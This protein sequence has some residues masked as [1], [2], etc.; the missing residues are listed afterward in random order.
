MLNLRIRTVTDDGVR[1]ASSVVIDAISITYSAQL[2]GAATLNFEASRD[3]WEPTVFPF[4]AQVEYSTDGGINY[5]PLPEHDLFIFERDS[6]D[7]KDQGKIVTYDGV[8]YVPWLLAGAYVGTGPWQENNERRINGDGSFNAQAGHIMSYFIDES[9]GR[10]WLSRLN[11]GFNA[12]LDSAGVAWQPSDYASIAWRLETFYTDVLD[13]L[14]E[15]GLCDWSATG[16]T[17]NLY[18]PDTLGTEKHDIV[19]GGQE[20]ERVPVATDHTGWYTHV[21]AISD[22]GRVHVHNTALETRFGRRSAVMSQTGVNDTTTSTKLA[23]TMLADGMI[24][25]RQEGYEWSPSSEGVHPWRDF[26]IGDHVTARARGGKRVRRVMGLIVTQNTE[27]ASVQAMVGEMIRSRAERNQKKLGSLSVGNIVGGSGGGYPTSPGVPEPVPSAPE[28]VI[29]ANNVGQWTDGGDPVS[30]VT[31]SWSPVTSSVDGEEITIIEYEVWSRTPSGN[32]A[33]DTIVTGTEATIDMWPSGEPR[34]VAV[35]ARSARGII[36]DFSL[37]LY[38]TPVYPESIVPKAPTNLDIVSNTATF[39]AVGPVAN[40]ILV[41]DAVTE[42]TDD[43]PLTVPEYEVWADGAP[44]TRIANT[45]VAITQPS[46]TVREYRVGAITAQGVR[47]D[48][49]TP[50]SV[51]GATPD[52]STATP[53]APLL[54]S[55]GANIIAAWD[56]GFTAP[57]AGTHTV[58]VEARIGSGAWIRQGASLST[59]GSQLVRLGDVGDTVEVR[60]VAI[61]PLGRDAGTSAT[62][63]ITVEGIDGDDII[64]GTIHGNRIEVGTL[65]VDA[66]EPNFGESLNLYANESIVLMAERM[67]DTDNAVADAQQ[68]ADAALTEAENAELAAAL[69][70]AEAAAA[71]GKALVAQTMAQD[72]QDQLTSHQA[73]FRVIS[74]GAEVASIDGSNLV[75]ITP[76]GVQ[77]VQGGTA[78]STWDAGRL[79][80]NEA[81]VNRAQVGAHSFERYSAGRT[82]IRPI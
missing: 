12:T 28:G 40:I 19:L 46:S 14:A 56:G 72:A 74:T 61:D 7:S 22:A 1:D 26:K 30:L 59:A 39:T 36:S 35:R 6:D 24:S 8:G 66:V 5:S 45:T 82:I 64:A 47:G 60:F 79:I 17:L 51:T 32:L 50:F 52:V 70:A 71:D 16:N 76:E 48:L 53:T 42:S 29:I 41:W 44:L 10:G 37:E 18:R 34:L 80:V 77:I 81:I 33:L 4:L 21:I 20:F 13:Q 65:A 23:N 43:T 73:V 75:R 62:E 31:V 63:S 2:N 25:D 54:T 38:F 67:D 3:D 11:R 55:G 9:K 15:Q 27:H 57:G 58:R 68:T 49:S 78:A 69:A